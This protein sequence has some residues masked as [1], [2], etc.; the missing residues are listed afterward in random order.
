MIFNCKG[1][2][3]N[4]KGGGGGGGGGGG[5]GQCKVR[6]LNEVQGPSA[7]QNARNSVGT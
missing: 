4:F 1:M 6:I 7:H 2:Q 5:E 3:I